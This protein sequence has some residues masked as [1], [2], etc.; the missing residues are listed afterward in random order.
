MPLLLSTYCFAFLLHALF[1][2]RHASLLSY[3]ISHAA[4]LAAVSLADRKRHNAPVGPFG[5]FSCAYVLVVLLPLVMQPGMPAPYRLT[6]DAAVK[7]SG[8][9]LSFLIICALCYTGV[10]LSRL[11]LR[12]VLR[13]DSRVLHA[14]FVY[15]WWL[16]AST[17]LV[18]IY[19]LASIG[20][21]D[22][23]AYLI[24]PG[25][26]FEHA[27]FSG[28]NWI[29]FLKQCAYNVF[30][31]AFALRACYRCRRLV[32]ALGVVYMVLFS[33]TGGYKANFFLPVVSVLFAHA[34]V[35]RRGRVWHLLLVGALLAGG[36]PAA[37]MWR[38]RADLRSQF[39]AYNHVFY[40]AARTFA[41]TTPDSRY[42]V[43]AM[44][45]LAVTPVPRMF[46]GQKPAVYGLTNTDLTQHFF[47]RQSAY[48]RGGFTTMGLAEAWIA[49]GPLGIALSGAVAGILLGLGARALALK[50]GCRR[51]GYALFVLASSYMLLRVSIFDTFVYALALTYV[52]SRLVEVCARFRAGGR[53][54]LQ[55]EARG[56]S[57]YE[58]V[59]VTRYGQWMRNRRSD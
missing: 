44:R 52:L 7:G 16:S 19:S 20:N 45:D 39:V 28:I 54:F 1:A 51:T 13:E 47:G 12:K 11:P 36:I 29:M 18:H 21:V 30:C 32:L 35:L 41:E 53:P 58:E 8:Y 17:W 5:V 4:V 2:S 42:F 22:L 38:D 31:V 33:L 14:F 49:L 56:S 9:Y 27:R 24:W 3:A 43:V 46:W 15:A 37:F 26:Q 10:Q 50:D 55:H 34:L 48:A 57:S 25:G 23:L 40:Y 6:Y 59:M